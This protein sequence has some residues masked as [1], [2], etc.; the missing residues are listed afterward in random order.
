MQ[1]EETKAEAAQ[2]LSFIETVFFSYSEE[3]LYATPMQ[4]DS[5]SVQWK[6]CYKMEK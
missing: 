5:R 6:N 1:E 2:S 4:T 3:L